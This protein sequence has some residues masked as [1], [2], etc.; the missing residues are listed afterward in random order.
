[1]KWAK[2]IGLLCAGLVVVVFLVVFVV[3]H[4]GCKNEV[5]QRAMSPS[6]E[7]VAQVWESYCT[8]GSDWDTDVTIRKR[9]FILSYLPVGRASGIFSLYGPG[10]RLHLYWRSDS[11]LIVECRGCKDN[12][13]RKSQDR[14]NG[15]SIHYSISPETATSSPVR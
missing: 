3:M 8:V 7:Y 1:M 13:V 12:E 14:W 4:T 10:S 15:I 2:W 6:G 5:T 9:P 11:D